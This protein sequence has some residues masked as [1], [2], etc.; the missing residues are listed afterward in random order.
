MGPDWVTCC[1]IR[2]LQSLLK[3]SQHPIPFPKIEEKQKYLLNRQPSSSC[4][5]R[6]KSG[7]RGCLNLT[8]QDNKMHIVSIPLFKFCLLLKCNS[9]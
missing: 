2:R 4:I 7:G 6:S 8:R 3:L 1:H 5:Y 9:P